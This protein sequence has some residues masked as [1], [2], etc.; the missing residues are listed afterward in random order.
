M[1]EI[2]LIHEKVIPLSKQ[3]KRMSLVSF[4]ILVWSITVVV[5]GYFYVTRAAQISSYSEASRRLESRNAL[6]ADL[7]KA[8]LDALDRQLKSSTEVL[9][10]VQ[11]RAFRWAP[12]LNLL[13]AYLPQDVWFNRLSCRRSTTVFSQPGSRGGQRVPPVPLGEFVIE[14]MVLIREGAAGAES[15]EA[16]VTKLR[17]DATFMEGIQSLNH[18]VVGR[19]RYGGADVASFVIVCVIAE[20]LRFDA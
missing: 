8:D 6:P 20:G 16:F 19:E 3:R 14:G 10:A 5:F 2:N 17:E 12:K 15:L 7:T 1:Y 4:Y 13:R 11:N 18:L 9:A